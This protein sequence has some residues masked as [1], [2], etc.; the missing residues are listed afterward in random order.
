MEK[1]MW[2]KITF[3]LFC[4]AAIGC[5]VKNERRTPSIFIDPSELHVKDV[6]QEAEITIVLS[7][8]TMRKLV[9][10]IDDI[11]RDGNLIITTSR[12]I[13]SCASWD[14]LMTSMPNYAGCVASKYIVLQPGQAYRYTV[15]FG[16]RPYGLISVGLCP[17]NTE[18]YISAL[19][20]GWGETGFSWY[21][22]LN[23][24]KR[25]RSYVW[26]SVVTSMPI[27]VNVK[28]STYDAINDE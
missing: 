14:S 20:S 28:H 24:P 1:N 4:I 27:R 8:S 18:E 21:K 25:L 2:H 5:T 19:F 15:V 11:H 7:N 9:L 23:F 16:P 17:T 12:R 3:L 10:A 22:P 26:T 13:D 6:Y